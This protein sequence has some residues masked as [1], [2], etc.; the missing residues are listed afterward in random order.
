[1]YHEAVCIAY[2]VATGQF[3]PSVLV[4]RY[5][6]KIVRNIVDYG[7]S[8]QDGAAL[9]QLCTKMKDAIASA[10]NFYTR[11][12]VVGPD[13]NAL[14]IF[15]APEF[16]F[17]GS[18]GAYD[19]E[20]AAK[21]LP[22]LRLETQKPK[23]K[24]WLFVLGTAIAATFIEE[25]RCPACGASGSALRKAGPDQYICGPCGT[26]PVRP[27][28]IGAMIDNV[29][30]IQKGGEA[31]DKNACIVQKEYVSHIDFRRALPPA[32]PPVPPRP[33]HAPRKP[34][35]FTLPDW[36]SNAPHARDIEIR[37]AKLPAFPPT[38]SRDKLSPGASK[39]QDERMGGSIFT[40]DGITFGLE[41][42]LDHLNN[43]LKGAEGVQIQ[44]VPS[45]G[46][47]L[48]QLACIPKGLAF[49]VDGLSG[50][51]CDMRVNEGTRASQPYTAYP[52]NGGGRIGLYQA[53]PIAW[54]D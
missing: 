25:T 34:F 8:V 10:Y 27:T 7:V 32:P 21:I 1:K 53:V 2:A 41:I 11:N 47:S 15:M 5:D 20:T 44:L 39:F 52:M 49:N 54:P 28:R 40:I 6:G 26:S 29:A 9:M 4:K 33:G 17:R 22:N 51:K 45:A 19:M 16:F 12:H 48:K 37:G 18:S 35:A 23:Y 50:G 30:L 31:D 36:S 3:D 24:D 43:R 42:C 46:A 13:D 38:G 14:K